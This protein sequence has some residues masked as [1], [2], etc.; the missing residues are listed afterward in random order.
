M[1]QQPSRY[2]VPRDIKCC[3]WKVPSQCT[4]DFRLSNGWLDPAR[5]VWVFIPCV[6]A[7][8]PP[9]T[10]VPSEERQFAWL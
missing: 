10:V 9:P 4:I 8:L 3:T 1:F 2:V 7:E 5:K 6:V